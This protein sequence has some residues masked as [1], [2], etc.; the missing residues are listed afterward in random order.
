[1]HSPSS[2]VLA[3]ALLKMSTSVTAFSASST[4]N[5]P[6]PPFQLTR[7]DHV[8]LRCRNYNAMFTFY[9]GVLGCTIDRPADVGRFGGALTHLRAGDTMIDLLSYDENELTEEGVNAVLK[10]HGGGEG[11][12]GGKSLSDIASF[13]PC[14]SMMDHLCIRADPFNEKEI[15]EFMKV[16][17]VDA[18]DAGQRYG[19]EGVGPSIYVKDPEGNVV[20]LKGPPAK[21]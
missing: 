13:D 12:Q 1:M 19:S 11:A 14:Q 17:G 4:S 10:M 9:T 15:I 18:I 5:P 3:A 16:K 2:L 20:E 21:A 8:V 6:P 7:L